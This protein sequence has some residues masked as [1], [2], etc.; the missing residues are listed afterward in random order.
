MDL[1]KSGKNK[2]SGFKKAVFT[3]LYLVLIGLISLHNLACVQKFP[4]TLLC[5]I[6]ISRNYSVL[7]TNMANVGE[8]RMKGTSQYTMVIYT[9]GGCRGGVYFRGIEYC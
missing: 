2:L 9:M 5:A 8:G 1:R 3:Y 7:T 4:M 6:D